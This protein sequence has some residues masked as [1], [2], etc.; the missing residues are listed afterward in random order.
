MLLFDRD[1]LMYGRAIVVPSTNPSGRGGRWVFYG[2]ALLAT[3][4]AVE[5]VSLRVAPAARA[6][7][8]NPIV[9]ENQQPGTTSWQL[10]NFAHATNHEIEGYAS[11]TS[12]NQ[13]GT[14]Q[15]MV[16]TSASAQYNLDIYRMGWYPNGTN[17]DGT[18]CSP[19][20]GGRLMQ[21]VGPLAG[22]VQPACPQDQNSSDAT[23]G[24]TECHWSP[25]Y[26]LNVPSGWTTGAYLVKLTRLDD[27]L[28][29]YMTFVVRA[30]GDNA[31]IAY[32]LDV[33]TWQAYNYWGGA[34]N[35]DVGISLYGRVNDVSQAVLNGSRA[36][37]VSFDRPY[38]VNGSV[39]GAG[40]LMIWDFP[41]IRWLES[42]GYNIDYVT[43]VDLDANPSVLSGHRVLV[44]VGHDEY[45]SDNMRNAVVNGIASGVNM[46]FFSANDIYQRVVMQPDFSGASDRR[47]F[48]DKGA[49]SGSTTYEW[50]YL[51][52][53]PKPENAILGV[54]QNGVA[55]SEPYLI[56][57]ASS[58][59]YNG[60]GLV[61]YTG[62]GTTGVVTSGPGQNALPGLV[63]YEFDENAANCSCL[64]SY[65]SS[66]PAGLD[67]VGHSNVPASDNGV[68]AW[69]DATLYTAPSG[70]QVFAAGTIQWAFAVDDG[71]NDGWCDCVHNVA[72]AIGQ[73]I[74]SNIL[75]R[76]TAPVIAPQVT[77]SPQSLSF[78]AQQTGTSSG[79]QTVTLS[80]TGSAALSISSISFTGTNAGDFSQTNNCP[81]SLA[82]GANCTISVSFAPTGA[83]I[84]AASLQVTDNASDSPESVSLSGTGTAP[85]VA[86]APSSLTFGSQ[87]VGTT[88]GAQT[89]TLTNSGTAP[90]TVSSI[91]VTGANAG[92][93]AEANSCPIAPATLA[94][95]GSC[96][97]S[98]TFAPTAAGGRTA[99]IQVA[100]NAANSPQNVSLSGSG[101]AQAPAVTL[102]P[103]SVAF[104][105]QQ[106]GDTS[107]A[108]SILL[109]NTGNASLS[110]GS[111][112]I[113]GANSG[114]FAQ[115]NTCPS[116]LAAG[117]NCTISVTFAPAAAGSRTAS[118]QV[119]DN[120]G[121]S[122]QSAP[123]S[124]TGTA[125]GVSLSPTSLAFGSQLL[126]S[127]STAQTVTLT[128]SGAAP[129]SINGISVTGANPGDFAESDNCPAAPATLAANATCSVSITF[130][131]A[132]AGSRAAT[133]QI[134]DNAANSP[135]SFSV[136]G[137]GAT[138]APAVTL[139]K[140]S[141]TFAS[142]LT[143]TTS[144][145]QSVTL[146]NS[147]TAALSLSG[148]AVTGANAGDFAETDN[149][150]AAP[151]TLAINATCSISVTFS[152]GASGSRTATVQ[153]TDN[154]ANSPQSFS[155]AGT[156]VAP[157]VGLSPSSL[158]FGSQLIGLQ[159]APMTATVTNTGTAPLSISSIAIAGANGGDF[160]QTNTCPASLAVNANCTISVTF[161]PTT[162]GS[163][164]ASVAIT[165]NA[166]NSPQSLALSGTGSTSSISFDHNLGTHIENAGST[167]MKMTTT[168]AASTGARVFAFVSWAS[169]T[170][171]TLSSLSGGGLTWTVDG[172]VKGP[173]NYSIGIAS[174]NAPNGLPSATTLTATFSGSVNHGNMAA[175]SF[176]GVA[177]STPVDV[178]ATNSQN[179]VDNWTA[180][181]TTVN[182]N[183]LILGA[184]IRDALVANT[185]TAPN[186]L[187][188][189]FQN[190]NFYSSLTSEY[191]IVTSPGP[192]TVAGTWA[193]NT[194]GS[195]ENA[196]V[197]VAYKSR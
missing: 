18:S 15:F 183:D 9:V 128:N 146:T 156:G 157:A 13:G 181:I 14:I 138:P 110:V 170:P 147:G 48:D 114:D 143:G 94:V 177:T 148:I 106:V 41:M 193:G 197:V 169:T 119:S 125:P 136:S 124:G 10:T 12:V 17:P 192:E 175:A 141:L 3:L 159:S 140:S 178:V 90:L 102:S 65:A 44:N 28:Q 89:V 104:G 19:S 117:A 31:P 174:A 187:I 172:Q 116:S 135:Q 182:P 190:P 6:A 32:S 64:S 11:L 95:N 87:L 61:N 129:L 76:F 137:T 108:R 191:Q 160:A 176:L 185:A 75:N 8:S 162:T 101:V 153:V 74:T 73:R 144:S 105:S 2:L 188:Q 131:P 111:I 16:S 171:R 71:Y 126:G 63:G 1:Q 88:S 86:L 151:A 134:T 164:S 77:L 163:R 152:P 78:G 196:T 23:Y 34:G 81:S 154:A 166:P 37:T 85:T 55:T 92:D 80:N 161:K 121:D 98:A 40:N 109:T 58:W 82:N 112:A 195:I 38:E 56:H 93:F 24:M 4:L 115:T 50:R 62:N 167:T 30:D 122:P 43:D 36:Y 42:Q 66:E 91:S 184:S 123:L 26:T 59:I 133:V 79:P 68:Q 69:S 25:S 173:Y 99:A 150:P 168:A 51:T 186:V 27:G 142:Q 49:L 39:D 35:N 180:S 155:L 179:G 189:T 60:T 46:A 194:A 47:V 113:A 139:S 57:D 67:E 45:Y 53:T 118:V 72:S 7:T 33:N 84:R 127:T 20:C 145:A 97:I 103:T 83:G 5:S 132:A 130:S 100:D 165:D 107:S 52:P 120:A 54:M 22:V 158:A 29:N 149:C 70:A 96:T 21:H